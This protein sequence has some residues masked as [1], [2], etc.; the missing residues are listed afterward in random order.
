MT[1]TS[2]GNSKNRRW[3]LA[4]AAVCI[5]A[6]LFAVS[7]PGMKQS[8][9]RNR[10][11]RAVG[12][13][14]EYGSIQ[15]SQ[16]GKE[17]DESHW[18]ID[19]YY[20]NRD[21]QPRWYE[22]EYINGIKKQRLMIGNAIYTKTDLPESMTEFKTTW[23]KS[24]DTYD[25]LSEA[26]EGKT[27]DVSYPRTLQ[28]ILNWDSGKD[29]YS[30]V[31]RKPNGSYEFRYSDADLKRKHDKQV[32]DQKQFYEL[33][34]E[35]IARGIIDNDTELRDFMGR[36]LIR[37]REETQYVDMTDT[38][39]LDRGG[40]LQTV[41]TDVNYCYKFVNMNIET[42]E[43]E[44]LD[45]ISE[46]TM[47]TVTDVVAVDEPSISDYLDEMVAAFEQEYKE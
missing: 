42:G 8:Y 2:K 17:N 35:G 43:I 13:L 20:D 46:V 44:V 15:L 23:G 22:I 34:K 25:V 19:T 7:L 33:Q 39:T 36:T 5:L 31:L 3:I 10:C 27:R 16:T 38:I 29:H 40:E 32:E 21:G 24:R 4:G 6:I 18:T 30:I 45:D 41:I 9:I 14:S 28:T 37:Q 1:E 11:K 12:R 47:R 26:I